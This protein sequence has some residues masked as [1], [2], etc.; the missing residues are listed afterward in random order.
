VFISLKSNQNILLKGERKGS[1][2]SMY[3]YKDLLQKILPITENI[4]VFDDRK[5]NGVKLIGEYIAAILFFSITFYFIYS[6]WGENSLSNPFP[7]AETYILKDLSKKELNNLTSAEQFE[8]EQKQLK[9]R[10]EYEIVSKKWELKFANEQIPFYYFLSLGYVFPLITGVVTFVCL[11]LFGLFIFFT[12]YLVF[13]PLGYS[14]N[15]LQSRRDLYKILENKFTYPIITILFIISIV[16][17]QLLTN[18]ILS[19]LVLFLIP[20]AAPFF[21]ALFISIATIPP[22]GLIREFFTKSYWKFLFTGK[23]VFTSE[24]SFLNLVLMITIPWLILFYHGFNYG[25][26]ETLIQE[27]ILAICLFIVSLRLLFRTLSPIGLEFW[28]VRQIN[29]QNKRYLNLYKN[30]F[31]SIQTLVKSNGFKLE[32][33]SERLKDNNIIVEYAVKNNGLALQFASEDLK[34]DKEIVLE[35]IKSNR[36]AIQFASENLKNDPEIL[37]LLNEVNSEK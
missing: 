3:S 31:L 21:F 6:E 14:F 37:A 1:I 26:P 13:W 19:T 8:Y 25:K 33:A 27:V 35:A 29:I 5:N 28:G 22:D 12:A 36:E 7:N 2:F 10:K 9:S 20:I 15:R 34:N 16:T 11:S 18:D 32:F 24:H 17:N 30:D 23:N 4:R